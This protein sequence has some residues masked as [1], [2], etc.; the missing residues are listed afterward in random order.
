MS[1]TVTSGLDPIRQVLSNGA[2]LIMQE[3]AFSPAVTINLAF[4]A[5]SLDEPDDRAGLAWF[6]GRVIDRGTTSRT[7]D[8]IAEALDDRG[9]ALKVSTNRH[10]VTLSCTCLVEDFHDVLTVLADVA[11]NPTFPED[12]IEKRRAETITA[13]RQDHDNTGVRAAE[14]LQMLLYGERHPYG[15]PAKGTI[16]T[17]ER[18]TRADLVEH[19]AKHFAPA[20]LAIVVVGDVRAGEAASAVHTAFAG[21]DNAPAPSREVPP[22]VRPTSR[23]E[24]FIEMPEK[25]QADIA[26]G[27]TSISRLDPAYCGHWVMNNILGQFGLGGRLAENIR[28]RQG[29]AYYAFSSFDPSLGPGPLVIRAGVD[30]VNV[31]RAIAAIDGEV[32]ALGKDG[33]T[34][35]ELAET[36]QYLIGSIPRMLETNQSI[37]TF[38][39]TAEFFGLGLDYDRKLPPLLRAVSL[40]DVKAAAASVLC[41]ER[42]CVAVAGPA[43]ARRATVG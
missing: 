30:P 41:P 6:L 17:V 4:T 15:R 32:G 25:S 19:H 36:R 13:I 37:A 42:A 16:A 35:R 7:A 33:A 20:T 43:S 23:R 3:T 5:G 29:M 12:E 34:E 27:F 22:V 11:K 38:L 28:E 31:E 8:A 2:V 26:Y 9:V 39:Q 10:V 14:A 24:L 40:E 21:W 18:F 1:V